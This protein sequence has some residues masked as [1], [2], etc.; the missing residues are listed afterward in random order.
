MTAATRRLPAALLAAG[1]LLGACSS[2]EADSDPDGG[3]AAA[4][5]SSGHD[6][7]GGAVVEGPDD[8]YAGIDLPEP[9]QRPSFTLTDTSG[10]AYDFAERTAGTPTLLFFGYTNCPDICPTTMAD[11][12]LAYR[13]LDPAV[14]EQVQMVFVTTDPA[15]DTAEVLRQYLDR[16]DADLPVSFVG[17]TGDQGAIDR[18]Q[19]AAGVPLAEE[20]GRLH[21]TQMNLYGTDDLAH[22]AFN[23]GNT[24]ADIAGDLV[25][26]V[27]E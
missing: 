13:R 12:A 20:Q 27:G 21:S 16:F 7:S 6:H 18:A 10:A 1:L 3:G 24:A 9:Y 2:A 14:A 26:V 22:V 15:T 19:L 8:R 23:G 25:T 17:L 5:S 11:V 4:S